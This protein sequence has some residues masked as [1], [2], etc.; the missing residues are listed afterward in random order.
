MPGL[1]GVLRDPITAHLLRGARYTAKGAW[2]GATAGPI[3]RTA[4]GAGVGAAAGFLGTDYESP[5]LTANAMLRGAMF[6]GLAGFGTATVGKVAA[7]GLKAN[8]ALG[9]RAYLNQLSGPRLPSGDFFSYGATGG[10]FNPQEAMRRS[11]GPFTAF[12]SSPMGFATRKFGKAGA[13]VGRGGGKYFSKAAMFALEHPIATGGII[14]G[15]V[16]AG[17]LSGVTEDPFISPTMTGVKVNTK[18]DQQAIAASELQASM[19]SPI[20]AVGSAPQMMGNMHR[21][22]M[23]STGGLVQGLHRG[24]H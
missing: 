19:I 15:G 21:T 3:G 18:Y 6:G 23:Q 11:I 13:K 9:R 16:I 2:K 7:K 24:R 14:G 12:G 5:T 20:G 1:L 22:M 4:F 8:Q 17:K 10:P